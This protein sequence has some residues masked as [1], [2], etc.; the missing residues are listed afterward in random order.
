MKRKT[1]IIFILFFVIL[2]TNGQEKVL[3]HEYSPTASSWNIL[4]WNVEN[5]DEKTWILKETLD[6]KGRVILLEFLKNGKLITDHLCYLANKV[7][8]EYLDNLIIET[9][10][11]SDMEL[12]ATDCEMPYKSIYH[13]TENNKIEKI[14]FFSKYDFTN[15]KS[16]EIEKWKTE[17]A[18]EHRVVTPDSRMLQI[19]YYYHS[20]GKM[21][22][23]YP[24]S[25]N[26]ILDED[27]YYYGDEPEKTSIENGI[28]N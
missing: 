12:L 1:H 13:L 10:Y 6:S 27:S 4:E 3:Y 2:K 26:Y 21:N 14:E 8:F 24:V 20:F 16:N 28:K 7:R 18:P 25:K 19:D 9:L 15:I 22:G 11:D 23:V 17:W 5:K